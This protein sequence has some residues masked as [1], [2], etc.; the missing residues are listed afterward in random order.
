M[1]G[2]KARWDGF[3]FAPATP[4]NLGFLRALFFGGILFLYVVALRV[5]YT[6]WSGVSDAFWFPI[7]LFRVFPVGV[8]PEGVLGVLTAVWFISMTFAAVG[9]WTRW[10]TWIALIS[11][12]YLLALPHNFGKIHHADAILAITL[13][14]MAWSRCGDGW[15]MD[16][17]IRRWRNPGAG[18][19]EPSG[20]YTWPVRLTWTLSC[21]LF[22]GAG[23]SKL[24]HS[25][26]PWIFSENMQVLLIQHGVPLGQWLAQW[27]WIPVL[28]AFSAVAF[29]LAAPLALFSARA[30]AVV[31][32]SLL[33]MQVGIG[34]FMNVWF[35][36]FLLIYAFWAPWDRIGRWLAA[37]LG[38]EPR[39]VMI[40]DGD[41]GLCGRTVA[42]VRSLNLLGRV[43]FSNLHT[44]WPD[45]QAR[46]PTLDREACLT[47]MVVVGPGTRESSGFKAYRQLARAMPLGWVVLPFLYLP[48]AAQIGSVVYRR[49]ADRGRGHGCEVPQVHA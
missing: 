35:Y 18:S 40:Y 4:S 29:E 30:R 7:H 26:L 10:A 34:L 43:E 46:F 28:L 39:Y 47:E 6:A 23:V 27:A 19:V 36:Q 5:D 15:S 44:D 38:S 8:F 45:L 37:A 48:G 11:G 41:C 25:G 22:F 33:A 42:V 32:P 2:L 24:R 9:L 14:T 12:A 17:L 20:E 3:W 49:M 16:A 21:F 13:G 31:I 1:S